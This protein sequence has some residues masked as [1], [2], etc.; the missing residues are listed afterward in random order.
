MIDAQSIEQFVPVGCVIVD[1]VVSHYIQVGQ[2]PVGPGGLHLIHGL[3]RRIVEL[4]TR[5]FSIYLELLR[6]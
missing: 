5:H 1:P 6:C 3:C 2:D 4:V